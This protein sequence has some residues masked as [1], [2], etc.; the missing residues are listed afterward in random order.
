MAT[1]TLGAHLR[2]L[3]TPYKLLI[4]VLNTEGV[5]PTE[6][7]KKYCKGNLEKLI[8]FSESEKMEKILWRDEGE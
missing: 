8:E 3:L 7:Y 2:C 1:E 6:V 5:E 4:D